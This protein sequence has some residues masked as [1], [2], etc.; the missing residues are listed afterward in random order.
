ML[1]KRNKTSEIRKTDLSTVEITILLS[2]S[3]LNANLFSDM[4]FCFG[5][6]TRKEL[7][8]REFA[9][10][11]VG[12]DMI[13]W[14]Q[15]YSNLFSFNCIRHVTYFFCSSMHHLPCL[16]SGWNSSSKCPPQIHSP[17]FPVPKGSPPCNIK[18]AQYWRCNI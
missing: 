18:P 3:S 14:F 1:P 9:G 2:I 11:I 4:L 13:W 10:I 16:R 12:N 8:V 17:P 6:I 5:G 7:K 15:L